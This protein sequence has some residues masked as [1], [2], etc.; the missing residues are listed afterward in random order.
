MSQSPA[1][2][3]P[4]IIENGESSFSR[5]ILRRAVV[6]Q[7]ALLLGLAATGC[8]PLRILLNAYPEKFDR[9]KPLVENMLRAFVVTVIPGA[10]W[11]DPNLIRIYSDDYYAFHRYCGFFVFDLAK[12]STNLCGNERF[13]QLTHAQRKA[14]I[15]NGLDADGTVARLYGAAIF[16]AQVSFYS[17]IYD[18]EKGNN[19]VPEKDFKQTQDPKYLQQYLK[20]MPSDAISFTYAEALGGSPGFYEMVSLRAPSLA[21]QQVDANGKRLWPCGLERSTMLICIFLRRTWSAL[22]GWRIA[23][24][25][26]W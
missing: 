24:K 6:K 13:D 26:G 4:P 8:S 18:D 2:V 1:N 15:E 19:I 14:V 25:T 20:T 7:T 3:L 21:F 11:E 23:S 5:E 12:R 16:I 10:P 9:E 22:A 17:G